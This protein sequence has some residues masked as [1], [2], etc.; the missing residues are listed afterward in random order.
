MAS[1]QLRTL[2]SPPRLKS[3]S[4]CAARFLIVLIVFKLAYSFD[5]SNPFGQMVWRYGIQRARSWL[6]SDRCVQ[7]PRVNRDTMR[8]G[9]VV[10]L[11]PLAIASIALLL[12]ALA[13]NM[14]LLFDFLGMGL[15]TGDSGQGASALRHSIAWSCICRGSYGA[16][17]RR[18]RYHVIV[19]GRG[20][21][22]RGRARKLARDYR[23]RRADT[24]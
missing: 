13:S 18:T 11:G 5:R 15:R 24:R 6:V 17:P 16:R 7:K 4:A 14:E 2:S 3:F 1:S 10:P 21:R 8:F 22:S 12:C 20:W 23:R 19:L 9:S